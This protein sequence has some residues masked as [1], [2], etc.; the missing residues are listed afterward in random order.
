M[1]TFSGKTPR[2]MLK[3]FHF[4]LCLSP[5]AGAFP[6]LVA[7]NDSVTQAAWQRF[8]ARAVNSMAEL[9][10]ALSHTPAKEIGVTELSFSEF[11]APAGDGGM[12][13]TSRLR[14]L[15]GKRVRL[16]G[17]MVRRTVI[18]PGVFVVAPM[19]VAIESPGACFVT[20]IPPHAVHVHAAKSQAEVRMAYRPGRMV[21]TGVLEL[22]PRREADGRNS[23]VRLV[24]DEPAEILSGASSVAVETT[25]S[26]PAL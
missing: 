18:Q 5:I 20:E 15:A 11:L 12:E 17:Y 7:A 13:F 14:A 26:V 3:F 9:N 10:T 23:A 21:F 16:S 24:L 25:G 6:V 8:Q 19:P 4:T 22:G 2:S 1:K